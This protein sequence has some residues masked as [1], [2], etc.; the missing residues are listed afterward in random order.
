MK[1]FFHHQNMLTIFPVL[2]K[3]VMIALK[4]RQYRKS[5]GILRNEWLK[6][7]GSSNKKVLGWWVVLRV[8][9]IFAY[10]YCMLSFCH[11]NIHNK[12]TEPNSL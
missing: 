1:L 5:E 8:N 12:N 10:L 3:F 2:R 4:E 11:I 6:R 7:N 9:F